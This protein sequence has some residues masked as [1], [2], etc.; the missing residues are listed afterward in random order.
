M[1]SWF[2]LS[3]GL[4]VICFMFFLFSLLT[5]M[6]FI[7]YAKEPRSILKETLLSWLMLLLSGG[8]LTIG[9]LLYFSLKNQ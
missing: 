4:A 9:L 7:Q 1:T 2:W 5:S 3:G 8:W 6:S